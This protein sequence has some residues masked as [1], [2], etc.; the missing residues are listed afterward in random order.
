MSSASATENLTSE[1]RT[2]AEERRA[3]FGAAYDDNEK[4]VRE[5]EAG[6]HPHDPNNPSDFERWYLSQS[7]EWIAE[8]DALGR[9]ESGR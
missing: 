4:V 7:P 6:L 1:L 3:R 8:M 5:I 9:G 2:Q